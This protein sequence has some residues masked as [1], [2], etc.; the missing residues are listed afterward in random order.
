MIGFGSIV[1]LKEYFPQ[2]T[3]AE[4]LDWEEQ[5]EFRY[6]YMDGHIYAMSGGTVNHS[7]IAVNLIIILGSHLRGSGFRVF[8]SDAKVQTLASNSYCYPDLSVTCDERVREASRDENR[9]ADRFISYPCLIIEVLSPSTEAYDRGK[10]FRRYRRST[11]LQEY[12][13]VS[14]NEICVDVFQRNE[15]GSWE[16]TTY[17]EGELV[18]L[19]SVKLTIPIEEIYRDIVL[20]AED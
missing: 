6:E 4:Y 17:G 16:L 20:V 2:L 12:I 3:P 10:K 15:R 13:L 1:A 8:N 9:N 18:E 5:Q 14:T 19:K 7:Q 11:T